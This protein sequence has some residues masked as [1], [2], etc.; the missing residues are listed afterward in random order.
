MSCDAD[1]ADSSLSGAAVKNMT[2]NGELL[3]TPSYFLG[4]GGAGSVQIDGHLQ[5][6]KYLPRKLTDAELVLESQ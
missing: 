4:Q 1:D 5:W 2:H 6:M 3:D